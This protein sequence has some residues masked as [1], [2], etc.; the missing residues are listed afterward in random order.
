MQLVNAGSSYTI[1]CVVGFL[2][3]KFL[4]VT[5]H[6]VWQLVRDYNVLEASLGVYLSLSSFTYASKPPGLPTP[7]PSY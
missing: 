2:A 3:I 5:H 7:K 6:I 1:G 4:T